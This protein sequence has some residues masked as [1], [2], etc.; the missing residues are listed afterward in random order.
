MTLLEKMSQAVARQ[1]STAEYPCIYEQMERF[2]REQPFAGK[3]VLYAAPLTRNTQVSLLAMLAGGA[4]LTVSW[5]EI[6]KPDKEVLTLLKSEGIRCY[7]RVPD[8]LSFDVIL[9]CCGIHA[10]HR[11]EAGYVELTRSGLP[12]YEELKGKPCLDID[13]T[14]VKHIETVL[15]TGDGLLRA[16]KQTFGDDVAGQKVVLFGYGKVGQGIAKALLSSGA[17]LTIAE[18]NEELALPEGV[19]FISAADKES[20]VNAVQQADYVITATG[21]KNVIQ[22]NYSVAA[23]LEAKGQLINMGAEDEYGD[24]FPESSVLNGKL[25]FN[26]I[27]DEPTRMVYMD[28]IFAL[29]NECAALLLTQQWPEG[30]RQPPEALVYAIADQFCREHGYTREELY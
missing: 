28:P 18:L 16:I 23:F 2:A 25:P 8:T 24:Q 21:L 29:Y 1:F 3:R 14:F 7:E 27:L 20:V 26:F 13:S 6:V 10:N 30:I 11:A 22:D 5:P 15:G 4:E 9:D 17:N 19:S 12:Y